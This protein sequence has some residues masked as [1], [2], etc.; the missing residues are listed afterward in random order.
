MKKINILVG[1]VF[2][3]LLLIS[4]SVKANEEDNGFVYFEIN[5]LNFSFYDD[6]TTVWFEFDSEII[7]FNGN[8]VRIDDDEYENLYYF[9]ENSEEKYLDEVYLINLEFESNVSREKLEIFNLDKIGSDFF[10]VSIYID[11]QIYYCENEFDLNN[12]I[13]HTNVINYE[14]DSSLIKEINENA[15]WYMHIGESN[16]ERIDIISNVNRAR[17]NNFIFDS[18]VTGDLRAA[19]EKIGINRFDHVQES[20]GYTYYT[21]TSKISG[22]YYTKSINWPTNTEHIRTSCLYYLLTTNTPYYENNSSCIS[23]IQLELSVDR[24]YMYQPSTNT[25]S[26]DSNETGYRTYNVGLGISTSRY[27]DPTYDYIYRVDTYVKSD[28]GDKEIISKSNVAVSIIA[29]FDKSGIIGFAQ[30]VCSLFENADEIDKCTS[31]KWPQNFEEHYQS[32]GKGKEINKI[33]RSY[34]FESSGYLIKVPGDYL[35]LDAWVQDRDYENSTQNIVI[36]KAIN[37]YFTLEWRERG[38]LGFLTG[39]RTILAIEDE[40]FKTYAH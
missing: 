36:T 7:H 16:P 6:Y 3:F 18:G 34:K 8:V 13:D 24:V 22:I 40:M 2:S 26:L 20:W 19:V 4:L 37:Y 25:I 27:T 14:N 21:N 30:S 1:L 28:D 38:V 12:I 17:S 9:V 32:T 11:E 5:S 39:G 31:Y 23:T 33:I 35:C 10:R 15:T 29:Q